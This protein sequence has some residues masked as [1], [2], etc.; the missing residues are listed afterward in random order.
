MKCKVN[1]IAKIEEE[2]KMPFDNS[3]TTTLKPSV[4]IDSHLCTK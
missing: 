1:I 4:W 2:K 3:I